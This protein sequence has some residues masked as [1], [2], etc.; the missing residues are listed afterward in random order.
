MDWWVARRVPGQD[1]AE[2]VGRLISD[3]YALLYEVPSRRLADSGLLR[4][5]AAKLRDLGGDDADWTTVASILRD[6]YRSLTVG[7]QTE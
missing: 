3:E 1:S 6:S 7:L 2:Q 5:R 4:A